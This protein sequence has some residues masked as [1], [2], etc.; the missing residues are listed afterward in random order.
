MML[1]ALQS[2]TDSAMKL[3]RVQLRKVLG[4]L[5]GHGLFR[6]HLPEIGVLIEKP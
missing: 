3:N 4:L 5:T 1:T 2:L 6:K